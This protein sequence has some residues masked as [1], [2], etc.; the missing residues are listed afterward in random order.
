VF[1]ISVEKKQTSNLSKT[2]EMRDNLSSFCSH[3]VLIYLQPFCRNSLVMC[4]PQA[5]NR[6]K[7]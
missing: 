4:A 1:Q 5:E 2:H 6:K 7:H 3:V